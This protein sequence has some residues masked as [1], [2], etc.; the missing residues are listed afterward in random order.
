MRRGDL[1]F[2]FVMEITLNFRLLLLSSKKNL[3]NCMETLSFCYFLPVLCQAA[4]CF[5]ICSLENTPGQI[6]MTGFA[7][8]GKMLVY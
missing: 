6:F 3:N 4:S 1:L 5:K 7:S 2:S 8:G